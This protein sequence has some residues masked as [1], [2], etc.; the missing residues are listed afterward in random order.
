MFEIIQDIE[1]FSRIE[2]K[3][4]EL[5]T[6]GHIRIFQSYLWCRSSW[7]CFFA[8]TNDN[9]LWIAHWSNEKDDVILPTYIDSKIIL[10]F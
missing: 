1:G 7:D 8:D 10:H 6:D 2:T 5:E 3:W 9:K 4:R